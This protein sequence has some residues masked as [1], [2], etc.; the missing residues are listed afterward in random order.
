MAIF[1]RIVSALAGRALARTVGGAAA[2]PAGMVIGAA[3][4]MVAR[5]LGPLGMAGLA[6]G[7]WAI[8]KAAGKYG[9]PKPVEIGAKAL[10]EPLLPSPDPSPNAEKG[11]WPADAGRN[12]MPGR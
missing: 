10:G 8:G 5:R 6:V 3:L 4:P 9:A 12:D 11:L 2:G 1:G 7:A